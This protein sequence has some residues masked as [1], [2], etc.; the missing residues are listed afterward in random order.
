[1]F[2]FHKIK[3]FL[4]HLKFEKCISTKT[5]FPPP[6]RDGNANLMLVREPYPC[7]IEGTIPKTKWD[8][9]SQVE[10]HTPVPLRGCPTVDTLTNILCWNP[11]TLLTLPCRLQRTR[12][13]VS[14]WWLANKSVYFM[15]YSFLQLERCNPWPCWS[16]VLRELNGD[17]EEKLLRIDCC[18]LTLT[19]VA[20]SVP[21]PLCSALLVILSFFLSWW[22]CS[23]L[24]L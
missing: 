13:F 20:A 22:D 15:K 18:H 12:R 10:S 16:F 2:P 4:K 21:C 11:L 6:H 23:E 5:F 8:S 1:M 7:P 3:C 9:P 17:F 14:K 24:W 19:P